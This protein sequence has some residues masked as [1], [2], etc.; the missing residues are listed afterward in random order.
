MYIYPCVFNRIYTNSVLA[1]ALDN[2]STWIAEI[3]KNGWR[4]LVIKEGGKVVLW[5]RRNSVLYLPV[6]GV[7][8]A[9]R[10]IP[11][12]TILDGELLERRTKTVKDL[13]YG[14][15]VIR[16][17]NK[18]VN[19]LPL[20]Q[21]REMLEETIKG[22]DNVELAQQFRYKKLGLYFKALTEEGNE[23]IVLKKLD[24]VY[25]VSTTNSV[26]NPYWIKIRK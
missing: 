2:D 13:W 15:D 16:L 9:L 12:G 8:E 20:W 25:P 19:D 7:R 6:K 5:S 11:D 10:N 18:F 23:G 14:F 1:K 24:S 26:T 21:R 22:G 17:K 3:K 4:C